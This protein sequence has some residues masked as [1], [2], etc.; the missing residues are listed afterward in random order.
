MKIIAI[1]TCKGGT[2]KSMTTFNLAGMLAKTHRVLLIDIDP[3]CN[4]S[5]NMGIDVTQHGLKTTA[6]IFAGN[7]KAQEIIYRNPLEYLPNLD[8][9]PSSILL[10]ATELNIVNIAGREQIMRNFILDNRAI[11]SEY[12][13]IFFDQNATMSIINQNAFLISDSIILVTDVSKNG[14]LGA[15]L[16]IALWDDVR[17]RLR[18]A[19]N[20][21]AFIINNYD[22]RIGIAPELLEYCQD[23]EETKHL[24]LDTVIPYNA[25]IK[26][27]ELECTPI[28]KKRRAA[29]P[30]RVYDQVINELLEREVL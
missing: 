21:K 24:L 11:L 3:Q 28:N 18:K 15:D 10:T 17:S 14:V 6:N 30:Q 22:K 23:H 5:M 13:Y 25:R 12:D 20:I 26:E 29:M 1:A 4:L 8:L 9:I 19:D 7:A 16:F 2:G 27:T